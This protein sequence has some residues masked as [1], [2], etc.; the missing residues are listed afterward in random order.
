VCLKQQIY[1]L[2][3]RLVL[4]VA[5]IIVFTTI[6]S[7]RY[8]GERVKLQQDVAGRIETV[9]SAS[10]GEIFSGRRLRKFPAHKVQFKS[11]KPSKR[12]PVTCKSTDFCCEKWAV[13][14]TIF[15]A[16][17]TIH[18]QV[19]LK[20]WCLVVVFDKKLPPTYNTKWFAGEGNQAVV[21]LYPDDQMAMKLDF[22][23]RLPWNSFG[24]KNVGYLY[25]IAHGAK[26]IWDF[27]DDNML[28]FWIPDAAPPF[29]PTLDSSIPLDSTV[30]CTEPENHNWPTFNPYPHL[31][32]PSLPSWPRGL[33]LDDIKE[34]KC[35]NTTVK[36]VTINSSRIAVL[37]SLADYQPDVDAIY[38]FTM[39]APFWFMKIN[40]TKPLL[41]PDGV[42]TPYNAQAT[43]HF[44]QGFWGLYLPITVTGR[45]SDIWRS[46][47]AK[48]LFW[49]ADLKMGFLPKPLVVQDRN[50]H[51]LLGDLEAERDLYMKSKQLVKFLGQWKGNGSTIVEQI[52][53][54]WIALYEHKYIEYEDVELMQLWLRS[55]I[56]IGYEFPLLNNGS[57]VKVPVYPT[58][59]A[60]EPSRG[61]KNC[62]VN[63]HRTFWTSDLHDGTRIDLPSV[64]A[65]MGHTVIVAG[66]KGNLTPYPE[67]FER[68]GFEIYITSLSPVIKEYKSHSTKLTEAMIRSNFE[69]Y[70][71]DSKIKE[72]DAFI[73]SFPASMCE[74][75]MPFNKTI[76]FAPAHRYNLGRC[77]IQEFD[78]INQHL[79]MLSTMSNPKHILA[80]MSYYDHEYMRH[81]T[82]ITP[83]PLYSSSRLYTKGTPY[84][85]TRPEILIMG[86]NYTVPT[87]KLT[88]FVHVDEFYNGHWELS[89]L[90]SHRGIVFFPYAVMT[91]KLTEVYA[92]GIPLFMPS[93]K[94]LHSKGGIGPDRSSMSRFYCNDSTMDKHMKPHHTSLHPYSPNSN[95]RDAEFYWL[96][97][98]D[99]FYWPH[100]T[101]F[102]NVSDLLN[103]IELANFT[104]IHMLMLQE[105]EKK[106]QS[107]VNVLCEVTN[108]IEDVCNVPQKYD[109]AINILYNTSNLQVF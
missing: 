46:Y 17:T 28:K 49:E 20:E 87:N 60:K 104:N 58:N 31:G 105:S 69:Y 75:W 100:I 36:N 63:V 23:D 21:L 94:Y 109:L 108:N 72:T 1:T 106:F 12:S 22:V 48:R 68:R 57:E 73:C 42:F 34:I 107:L 19:K 44:K 95:D 78:R 43:L 41:V 5:C 98:A 51:N 61:N 47:I 80:A 71:N 11:F 40:E 77:S 70:K 66:R 10:T 6:Y 24:R 92:L 91:Y 32:A 62:S 16:S 85:P 15:E 37:Q 52:E 93:M 90:A 55:L 39:P 65:Y 103:K 7:L 86:R 81:Y 102:D 59:E 4:F 83:L 82:G 13:V 33:P 3:F 8:D 101:Y 29:V 97:M 56:D 9:A 27:D 30:E 64:L 54:L 38:R 99:Y 45:V 74:M 76:I 96:Q 84:D 53:E 79:Q 50:L 26:V 2:F 89:D 14:T 25:A 35:S 67:V 88:K 18:R